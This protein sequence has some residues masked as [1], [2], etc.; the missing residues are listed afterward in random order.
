MGWCS[1]NAYGRNFNESVFYETADAM[2]SNGMQAAGYRYINVDGGW[3]AGSDTG[4]IGRNSSGYFMYN[5][6]KYPHGIRA[7]SDY[8]HAHGFLYGHYTDAGKN[9]CNG[10][11]PM[12]EGYEHQDA[13]LFALEYGAD[14]VKVDACGDSLPA[15]ELVTRWQQ[16]LNKT[17]RPVFFSNCHNGCETDRREANISSAGGWQ[18]WCA[19]LSNMWRSSSDINS[20]WPAI[21]HNLDSLK[22]RGHVAGPGHWNDPDFLE[23]GV[24][25]LQLTPSST[26]QKLDENRA[27]MTMWCI[28]SSPLIAGLRMAPGGPGGGI[29]NATAIDILTNPVAIAI[30]QQYCQQSDCGIASGGDL[31]SVLQ[32]QA[33]ALR[34]EDRAMWQREQPQIHTPLLRPQPF[35]SLGE[36]GGPHVI[37]WIVAPLEGTSAPDEGA[38]CVNS[39][40]IGDNTKRQC[41]NQQMCSNLIMVGALGTSTLPGTGCEASSNEVY[42]LTTGA[43]GQ[44]TTQMRSLAGHC[45]VPEP[46]DPENRTS[47]VRL[48]AGEC[49][50]NDRW[51]HDKFTGELKYFDAPSAKAQCVTVHPKEGN[52]SGGK[53]LPP[54]VPEV[55]AKPLPEKGAAVALFNRAAA[56]AAMSVRLKDLPWLKEMQSCT[57]EDVWEG[58]NKTRIVTAAETIRYPAVRVHQAVLLRLSGCK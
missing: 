58:G 43:D 26:I 21:M 3:W 48:V 2:K 46:T 37:K 13:F 1:W 45:I 9:A 17:N 50:Q 22:G 55:W 12:S 8:I 56:P 4:H 52:G 16:Q 5:K 20:A 39:T 34:T 54:Q 27:H 25:N 23:V 11:R 49:S 6:I 35:P 33:Q 41:W 29:A 31:L 42:K 10:D 53:P 18:P 14:M 7:V 32:M 24:K 30:N 51:E 36:C 44:L 19:D 57:L 15:L 40:A 38:I 47:A 28:T